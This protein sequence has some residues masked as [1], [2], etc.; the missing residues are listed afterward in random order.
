[1]ASACYKALN[2]YNGEEGKLDGA[3]PTVAGRCCIS[4][5]WPCRCKAYSTACGIIKEPCAAVW[6]GYCSE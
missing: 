2:D 6:M 5:L 4:M 3:C 1:M